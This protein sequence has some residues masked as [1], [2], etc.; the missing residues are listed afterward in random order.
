MSGSTLVE[1]PTIFERDKLEYDNDKN[2]V[3]AG[4]FGEVFRATLRQTGDVVAVKVLN[5][6]QRLKQMYIHVVESSV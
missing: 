2:F 4:E 5:T 6:P 1:K 3:G